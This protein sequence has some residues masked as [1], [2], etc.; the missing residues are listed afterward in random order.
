[1]INRIKIKTGKKIRIN[2]KRI[3]KRVK[4]VKII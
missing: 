4:R 1:M 3:K 2:R